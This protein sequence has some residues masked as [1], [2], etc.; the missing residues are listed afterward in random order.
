LSAGT[1]QAR[2]MSLLDVHRA[3]LHSF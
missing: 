3:N 2:A 1:E